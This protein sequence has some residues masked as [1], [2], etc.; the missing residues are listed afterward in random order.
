MWVYLS[1]ELNK[2]KNEERKV[3]LIEAIHNGSAAT[4]KHFN[5]H[6]EFNFSDE[7]MAD[8]LGLALPKNFDLELS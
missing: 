4:W 3:E 1:R 7:Q 6:G 8:S 5:L 2:E